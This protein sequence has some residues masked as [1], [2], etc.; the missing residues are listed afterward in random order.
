M[1]VRRALNK[2]ASAIVNLILDSEGAHVSRRHTV[3]QV[4]RLLNASRGEKSQVRVLVAEREGRV[5]GVLSASR[6]MRYNLWEDAW[7]WQVELLM[8][9]HVIDALLAEMRRIAGSLPVFI[10]VRW[11]DEPKAG[12]LAAKLKRMGFAEH[13]EILIQEVTS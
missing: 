3:R 10:L 8:G 12:A 6:M 5:R 7:G 13:S 4:D 1:I 2:D 11:K 9:R